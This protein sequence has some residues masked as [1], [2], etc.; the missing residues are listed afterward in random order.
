MS[1]PADS[2]LLEI[3]RRMAAA[4][5]HPLTRAETMP[6]RRRD[7]KSNR[8]EADAIIRSWIRS[9]RC[10]PTP[11]AFAARHPRCWN[12]TRTFPPSRR[13]TGKL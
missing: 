10:M 12:G 3:Q 8:S 9:G 5:M 4:V 7:G 13:C 1:Q 2:Q 11:F 6:Q